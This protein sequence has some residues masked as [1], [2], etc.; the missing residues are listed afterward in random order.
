M[1]HFWLVV[2]C[3]ASID[4]SLLEIP[5]TSSLDFPSLT[6]ETS[7]LCPSL[8]QLAISNAMISRRFSLCYILNFEAYELSYEQWKSVLHLSTLWGFAS[9][10]KLALK[11]IK[12]PTDHDQLVLART[13]S[14]DQWVLPA[15]TAL[16]SRAQPLSLEEAR[17][18][19]L[20][21]VVLL[22]I[23]DAMRAGE[24]CTEDNANS[25]TARGKQNY[26]FIHLYRRQC[27]LGRMSTGKL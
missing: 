14:V 25:V 10:R 21:D 15:L 7:K 22:K 3:T 23:M 20:E 26:M 19:G 16:C 17:E 18:M 8:Y 2:R 9:L 4:T 6:Y 13:Y 11:S 5:S 12:P 24:V 27:Q 1:S